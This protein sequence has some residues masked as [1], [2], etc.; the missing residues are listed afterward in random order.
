MGGAASISQLPLTLTKEQVKA[1]SGSNFDEELFNAMADPTNNTITKEQL[2]KVLTR[3]D[4]FLTH[5]WGHELGQD[6]HAKVGM[7][8]KLIKARGLST[9]FD[10]EKMEGNI[11]KQMAAGIDNAQCVVV[12]ITKRYVDKVAGTNPEDN[13]QLEFN[14]SARRKGANKIIAVVMEE[15]MRNDAA[16]V[17]E[18]GLVL[19]GRLYADM[20]GDFGDADYLN[21]CADDLYNRI[22]KVIGSPV[23]TYDVQINPHVHA[24]AVGHS[25]NNSN[26]GNN[27]SNANDSMSSSSSSQP[28]KAT[29]PL[30]SLTINEVS[31]L[32]NSLNLGKFVDALKE[33]EVDG[34]TLAMCKNE[35]EIV[36]IGVSIQLKARVLYAKIQSYKIEGVPLADINQE[37]TKQET[38]KK[39]QQVQ[40]S[41]KKEPAQEPKKES[42]SNSSS[43]ASSSSSSNGVSGAVGVNGTTGICELINGVYEITSEV[44][45]DVKRYKK[46]TE[47]H[48][49]EYN[50]SQK[51]WHIK[52]GSKK[53][54]TDAW[55][56]LDCTPGLSPYDSPS[57]WY[58]FDGSNFLVQ[59]QIVTYSADSMCVYG[60][61]IDV[62]NGIYDP[63][64]EMYSGTCRYQKRDKTD[65]WFE[66][67]SSLSHWH[68]TRSQ[69]KGTS[70]AFA[71]CVSST[72]SPP[73]KSSLS[74]STYN[75][76]KSAFES[77]TN[78][79]V[80]K[81]PKSL[82]VS[83]GS[84]S[85]ASYVAGIYDPTQ[86][87]FGGW[88]RYRKRNDPDS[89]IEY[90]ASQKQ[91]HIKPT[92][93]KEKTNAWIM[94]SSSL[95]D[96]S[97]V[98][99]VWSVY[100]GSSFVPDADFKVKLN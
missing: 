24:S 58:V 99:A 41:V 72:K 68:I 19:G 25:S 28:K 45:G 3:T 61:N 42:S 7:I 43:S 6:N 15:R 1:F 95:K 100:N 67:S 71:Y 26:G 51:R 97:E 49:I 96:P 36:E 4:V 70:Q 44:Y 18:V 54:T 12:F 16:W 86:E 30:N 8:N 17:G 52:P 66:Y 92:S 75:S 13:C 22:I 93:S 50:T 88:I 84:G 64:N 79:I 80:I 69:D 60:C 48:W 47:D 94:V 62:L 91:W 34:Q 29:K 33:N 9:W 90:M 98:D 37:S 46:K 83:G 5:D 38:P 14:Y 63:T 27:G 56:Y 89:W 87:V 21:R 55:A 2:I 57:S 85:T 32:L 82:V 81:E 73:W 53:G 31:T 78:M 74:W 77:A 39:P 10:E 23:P 35:E 59:N 65:Y 40:E 76:T 11:K 20:T